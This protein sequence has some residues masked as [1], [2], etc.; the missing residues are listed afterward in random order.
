[1][2]PRIDPMRNRYSILPIVLALVCVSSLS[3]SHHS[4]APYY[5]LQKTVT[6]TGNVTKIDWINPHSYIYLDVK[7]PTGTVESWTVE[8]YPT[9][10][11]SS[12]GVEKDTIKI[13]DAL[14]VRGMAP[15]SGADFSRFP[16]RPDRNADGATPRVTFGLDLTLADGRR[17]LSP[18]A[19]NRN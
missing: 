5:D 18:E 6:V 4:R 15:K 17:V 12:L 1:M 19:A 2:S 9:A 14:T 7:T 3:L 16:G 13:G 8:L 10:L 11:M